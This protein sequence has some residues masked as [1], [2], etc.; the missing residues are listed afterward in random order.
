MSQFCKVGNAVECF[1]IPLLGL[2][3]ALS[4]GIAASKTTQ[5]KS[6]VFDYQWRNKI[7]KVTSKQQYPLTKLLQI[8]HEIYS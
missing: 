4:M 7:H 6:R 1:G 5:S 2:L 3:A 8:L